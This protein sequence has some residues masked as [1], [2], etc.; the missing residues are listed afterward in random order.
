MAIVTQSQNV[1]NSPT[2]SYPVG[3]FKQSNGTELQAVVLVDSTGEEIAAFPVSGSVDVTSVIPGTGATNLGKATGGAVGA[4][5]VG[6]VAMGAYIDDSTWRPFNISDSGGVQVHIVDSALIG[7]SIQ[8]DNSQQ[9][10]DAIAGSTAKAVGGYA[11]TATPS[12]VTSD[13]D[14]VRAWF[15]RN[16]ALNVAD[17]GGSLT[18][19]GTVAATQSGTWT[20]QPGNTANSTAWLVNNKIAATASAGATVSIGTSSAT[21]IAS[22]ANRKG[23]VVTNTHASNTLTID[24]SGG[25]AVALRG[26]VLYPHDSFVM[27]QFTFTTSAITAIASAAS[28][29]V[30]LQELA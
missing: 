7:V 21:L 26:I 13:G 25:T 19:D 17:G 14:F 3:V 2:N 27:D 16:G 23:L 30:A 11:S 10:N 4:S 15:T 8:S 24:L 12:A 28:T 18:V 22:N 1:A 29:T 5:D 6:V 20:V 9:S